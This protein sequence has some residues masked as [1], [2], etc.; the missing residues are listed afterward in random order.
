M[1]K[2]FLEF[3]DCEVKKLEDDSKLELGDVTTV[4]LTIL[5]GDSRP[6]GNEIPFKAVFDIR[7]SVNVDVEEFEKQVIY[8]I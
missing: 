7:I 4:N 1:M 6:N 3:R 5:E 2:K 8:Q